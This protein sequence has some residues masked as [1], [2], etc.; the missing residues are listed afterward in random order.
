MLATVYLLKRRSALQSPPPKDEIDSQLGLKTPRQVVGLLAV[1]AG[2]LTPLV[3]V[4]VFEWSVVPLL[5]IYFCEAFITA[6]IAAVKALFAEL[7]S[8]TEDISTY[9]P[10]L[11]LASLQWKRGSLTVHARLPPIYPRNIPYSALIVS[12]WL[13]I[14]LPVGLLA[15]ATLDSPPV[16][17][18]GMALSVIALLSTRLGEFRYE[19]IGDRRFDDTSAR[20]IGRVLTQ[21]VLGLYLIVPFITNL[22]D[23]GPFML[24][25]IVAIRTIIEAYRYSVDRSG[26][27]SVSLFS[28]LE[29]A[30]LL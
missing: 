12:L 1:I 30:G 15:W 16:L 21:Q 29:G 6:L 24:G 13:V 14:G 5:V 3:G 23:A 17:S 11:P 9:T 25:A 4:V 22:S 10:S 18:I 7:G 27:P 20:E 19:F 26:G 8:P 28:Q 2:N